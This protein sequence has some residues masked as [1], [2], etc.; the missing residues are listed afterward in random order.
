MDLESELQVVL[1]KREPLTDADSDVMKCRTPD[2]E[3]HEVLTHFSPEKRDDWAEVLVIAE[4]VEAGTRRMFR[5]VTANEVKA[6]L[7]ENVG[8]D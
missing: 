4:P 7:W 5:A 8:K 6:L 1:V 2:G 3:L